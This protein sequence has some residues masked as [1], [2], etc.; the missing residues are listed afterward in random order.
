MDSALRYKNPFWQLCSEAYESDDHSIDACDSATFKRQ[1]SSG[2][3]VSFIIGGFMD[4]VAFEYGKDVCTVRKKKGF[5][6]YC[7]QHGY[8]AHPCYTFGECE[9]YYTFKGL[10]SVRQKIAKKNIPALA[11]FGWPLVP[12]LPLRS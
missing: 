6:K 8:R 7:L 5:I 3:N 11:F 1:M 2:V 12:F 9:T 10:K 4:A